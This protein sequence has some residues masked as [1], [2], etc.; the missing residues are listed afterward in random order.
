M[1]VEQEVGKFI[2]SSRVE[3]SYINISV[4]I[5]V[6]E[7][8][9]SYSVNFHSILSFQILRLVKQILIGQVHVRGL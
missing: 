8:S 3:D 5:A 1:V 2:Q 9:G 4:G 7:P 6:W